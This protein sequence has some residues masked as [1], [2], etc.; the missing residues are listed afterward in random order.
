MPLIVQPADREHWPAALALLFRHASPEAR[1][2]LVQHAVAMLECGELD[3][4][5]LNV[6][7]EQRQIVGAL[8][9]TPAPGAVGLLWPPQVANSS[10]A[11]D[12]EDDLIRHALSWLRRSRI[13]LCQVLLHPEEGLD[14]AP[15]LRNGFQRV[16]TLSFLH[17]QLTPLLPT[18][19][20]LNT[21][22]FE[23]LHSENEAQFATVLERT[24][25]GTEDCPEVNGVRSIDE[26][27]EGHR[28][29]GVHE[30][31][32]WWLARRLG[33]PVGVLLVNEI[34]DEPAWELVYMGVL[35]EVR[36]Q[37]LG[38]QLLDFALHESRKAGIERVEL[39]VDDRNRHAVRIYKEA[40]FERFAQRML[41]LA[42]L[43]AEQL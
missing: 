2:G 9:C 26:V 25:E 30:P 21:L 32:R 23:S 39:S 15:L 18:G 37:G 7:R 41:F 31:A 6:A 13:K 14:A 11:Q 34:R 36:G 12:V 29:Q 20:S 4:R 22:E 43:A 38:R 1:P 42:P 35:P 8:L 40:G 27:L 10:D 17:L 28:A 3:P 33:A 16:T 19:D 24:Y 5:G